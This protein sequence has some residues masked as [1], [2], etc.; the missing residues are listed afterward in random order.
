M[1]TVNDYTKINQEKE[2]VILSVRVSGYD[3]TTE[4]DL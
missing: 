3:D 1:E 4:N 2:T